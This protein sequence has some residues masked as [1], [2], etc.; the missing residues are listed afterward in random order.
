MALQKS[1][2]RIATKGLG[3]LSI[4]KTEPVSG[5][6]FED[7]GYIGS[8]VLHDT[9]NIEEI[10]GDDGMLQDVKIRSQVVTVETTLNQC[11]ADEIALLRNAGDTVH[12]VRYYG[13]DTP[14]RFQ[15][16]SFDC[17]RVNPGLSLEFRNAL[18]QIPLKF[19]ALSQ[20]E[21]EFPVPLYAMAETDAELSI[22]GLQLWVNPGLWLNG[23]TEDVLEISG[24]SR[25]GRI[26]G[27]GTPSDIWKTGALAEGYLQFNTDDLQNAVSFGNTCPIGAEDD[28]MM[29]CWL[30]IDT[31]D[32]VECR[33]AGKRAG[34]DDNAEISGYQL[35][36][37]AD[38]RI[39]FFA[40]DGAASLNCV[41]ASSVTQSDTM[42]HV[43]VTMDHD[44]NT[45]IYINGLADGSP[46]ATTVADCG[47]TAPLLLGANN[48]LYGKFSCGDFR[49][50]N[51]GPNGMPSDIAGIVARHFAAERSAYQST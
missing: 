42:T 4:R 51:F 19:W 37:G 21:R 5:S 11:G 50:H 33:I 47:T 7:V 30:R 29:E 12:A 38:N 22:E 45:Q 36:R 26:F 34:S 28:F 13:S 31:T 43:A 17:V 8:T 3:T 40:A 23:G 24:F 16:F 10:L 14:G 48:D 25:H 35:Y 15:Y 1:R 49:I 27:T 6:R 18:R 39:H 44:G 2:L 41:S 9:R 46:V 20:D 32:G